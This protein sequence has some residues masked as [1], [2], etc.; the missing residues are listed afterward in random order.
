MSGGVN[1]K[2]GSGIP[3]PRT[4]IP[5]PKLDHKPQ[6]S[7]L[8]RPATQIPIGGKASYP[9]SC[10]SSTSSRDLLRDTALRNQLQRSGLPQAQSKASRASERPNGMRS[11]F[12]SPQAPRRED[13]RSKDTLDV[14]KGAPTLEP[15]RELRRNGNKNCLSGASRVAHRKLDN[16]NAQSLVQKGS[17]GE[18]TGMSHGQGKEGCPPHRLSN[19]NLLSGLPGPKSSGTGLSKHRGPLERDRSGSLSDE[20]MG[21]PED[22]SPSTPH[23]PPAPA[24]PP[25]PPADAQ[26]VRL[27]RGRQPPHVNMAAI[28]PFR[29]R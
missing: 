15:L 14:R 8:P 29:Y 13:P 6:G 26:S 20:E 22:L 28:A 1:V 23:H 2:P 5:S 16:T 17:A 9:T 19:E 18:E 24:Q 7:G 4:V 11:A 10:T 3:L 25:A 27:P 12:S 21:T